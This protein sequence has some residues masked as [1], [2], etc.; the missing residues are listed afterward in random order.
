MPAAGRRSDEHCMEAVSGEQALHRPRKRRIKARCDAVLEERARL[1][2]EIHDTLLQ[3]FTGVALQLVAVT[4]RLTGSPEVAALRGLVSLAQKTL[5]DARRTVWDLRGPSLAEGDLPASLRTL[6]EEHTRAAALSF[7]FEV[8]GAPRPV[9]PEVETVMGRVLGEALT[10]I[11][12]HAAARGVRVRLT[13]EARRLRL[14]IVDD[15]RGFGADPNLK[16]SGGHWGLRGMWERVAQV[17][18][19]LRIRSTPGQGT[20]LVLLVPYTT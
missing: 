18:G 3:G 17:R 9:C 12:K 6:A 1:A 20:Q 19:R 10:N 4:N 8:S 13:F 14:H 16:G 5:V 2:R 15:G 11:V 7:E